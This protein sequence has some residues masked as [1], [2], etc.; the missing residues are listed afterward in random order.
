ML[1]VFVRQS[2]MKLGT[3]NG[4][5]LNFRDGKLSWVPQTGA[6]GADQQGGLNSR[7]RNSGSLSC[8][9][10]VNELLRL[11]DKGAN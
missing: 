9:K 7:G 6:I 1:R 8:S 2:P 4:V 11:L 5:Y 10:T 3:T